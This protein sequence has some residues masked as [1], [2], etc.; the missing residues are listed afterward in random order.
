LTHWVVFPL[1]L[2]RLIHLRIKIMHIRRDLKKVMDL[3]SGMI[4]LINSSVVRPDVYFA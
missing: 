2:M 3:S 1:G 4:N